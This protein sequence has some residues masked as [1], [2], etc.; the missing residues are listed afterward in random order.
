MSKQQLGQFYTTNYEYILQNL[1]IPNNVEDIIEPFCG[2][3]DLVKFIKENK[4]EYNLECYDIEPKNN[5]LNIIK[6]DTLLNPPN[7]NNKYVITNPPYLA[8]NKS[9]DKTYFDKY[10]ENDLYKC[11]MKILSENI[12]MGGILIIPLN[13]WTAIR[14]QDIES[15]KLFLSNYK[16]NR[17]NI[18]E[19]SVFDDTSYTICAFEFEKKNNNEDNNIYTNIYPSNIDINITLNKENNYTIGGEIYKLK[20]ESKINRLTLKNKEQAN[21]NLLLKCLDDNEDKQISLSYNKEHYIDN[22]P[23]L[24]ARCYATLIIEPK[25]SEEEQHKLVKKFNS[26]MKDK[27]TQ[28]HSLFLTNYRESKDNGFA[29]KRISFG[30]AYNIISYL[31]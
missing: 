11:F 24:S 8:R 20:G 17:L 28:Y 4:T 21:T 19:E 9:K 25:I 15:R 23:K 2:Q 27:R 16:V 1:N 30:L 12:C 18:F 29:R 26:F 10:N 3:G 13:F 22:T 31:L 6:Q 14:K 7:Y 5:E